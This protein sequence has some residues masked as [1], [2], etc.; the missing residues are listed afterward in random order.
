MRKIAL[1]VIYKGTE[2]GAQIH[3]LL[4]SV[5]PFVDA[6]YATATWEK[7]GEATGVFKAYDAVV[8]FFPWEK[9]FAKARNFAKDQIP[10]EYEYML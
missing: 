6:I 1:S 2:E 4:Q 10:D 9:D 7:E 5:A 8:S 3:K